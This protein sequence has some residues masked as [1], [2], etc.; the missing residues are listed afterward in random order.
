[1]NGLVALRGTPEDYDRWA[2]PLGC[3]GWGWS[4]L[5]PRFLQVE[6]DLDYGGDGLHGRGGPIPLARIPPDRLGPLDDALRSLAQFDER[7]AKVLELRFFGGLSVEDTAEALG[8][9]TAT[10]G[11]EARLAEAWLLREIQK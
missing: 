7:R 5:L 8:I 9:S 4:D 3:P 2:G 11:R 1:M 6:D 10:V